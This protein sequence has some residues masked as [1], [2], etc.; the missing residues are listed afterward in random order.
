MSRVSGEGFLSGSQRRSTRRI[1]SWSDKIW[2]LEQAESS[3]DASLGQLPSGSD[4]E[5]VKVD[6]QVGS[7]KT[8]CRY[9]SFHLMDEQ[10][11]GQSGE[12]V[13]PRSDSSHLVLFSTM[14]NSCQNHREGVE[15]TAFSRT[16]RNAWR[17]W[18]GSCG[19]VPL[20]A[21]CPRFVPPGA[22]RAL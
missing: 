5:G 20:P 9:F 16:H 19:G 11:E 12:A 8:I 1:H 15:R 4:S 18:C 13:L 10:T 7:G 17:G 3:L 2:E 22:G 14:F 6:P 21:V